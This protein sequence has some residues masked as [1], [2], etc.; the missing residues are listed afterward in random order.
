MRSV[1]PKVSVAIPTR[2]R[3]PLLKR[4]L[5]SVFAQ[6]YA[7]LQVVVLDDCSEDDTP[8]V[9]AFFEKRFPN[10]QAFRERAG[11]A[12][13]AIKKAVD[14]TEGEYLARL[15]DDDFWPDPDKTVLQVDFL[16]KNPDYV[17]VGGGLIRV[18]SHNRE[19]A[20]YLFPET[21]QDIRRAML[22]YTPLPSVVSLYRRSAVEQVGGFDSAVPYADDLDLAA[23]LGRVGKLHNLRKYLA[24]H[25]REDVKWN[26]AEARR[27][28]R[29]S[30]LI[31]TKYRKSYPGFWKGALFGAL[32]YLSA[33]V[34]LQ[35]L[36][37]PYAS[38]AW[39]F[40]RMRFCKVL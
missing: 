6:T 4:A 19:R 36:W 40:V 13:K 22:W 32:L 26:P 35:W 1:L 31:R 39:N 16:E 23:R 27:L 15:D 9:I 21:D 11:S 8:E 24:V 17:A 10:L 33:F 5:E 37:R 12:T 14:R 34:P 38:R 7:N 30:F 25:T 2:N 3:A 29:A 28:E 18:D 20:R